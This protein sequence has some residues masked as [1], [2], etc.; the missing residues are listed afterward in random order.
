MKE[1]KEKGA[2][3]EKGNLTVECWEDS[4][5]LQAYA[6]TGHRNE[7]ILCFSGSDFVKSEFCDWAY[8]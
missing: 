7:G 3:G 5:A 4:V 1:R 2:E 6:S 8:N